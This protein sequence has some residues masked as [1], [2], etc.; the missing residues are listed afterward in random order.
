MVKKFCGVCVAALFILVAMW[1][2]DNDK[3]YRRY[4]GVAWN[5]S[6]HITY[7]SNVSLDD[8]IRT[9]M[10]TIEM[11][12]SPFNVNSLLSKV[13][14]NESD[15]IDELIRRVF[16]KSI[17]VNKIS[18]SKF[19]P[20]LGPLINLWGFG[21]ASITVLPDKG[22]VDSVMKY[23]G[24][25]DCRLIGEDRIAKKDSLTEF[26]F[27]AVAKGYGCDLVSQMLLRNGCKDYMVEVGGEIVV[28]GLSPRK[29]PWRVMIDAPIPS[30]DSIIHDGMAVIE[31]DS[32]SLATSGNYRN[33]RLIDGQMVGHTI[34]GETGYPANS[35]ILSVTV[36]APECIIADGL[37][38]ACMAMDLDDAFQMI[39]SLPDTEALFVTM[40]PDRQW[41]LHPTVGFPEI[42]R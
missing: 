22:D 5:T 7:A 10:N 28:N 21:T 15:S 33:Y 11:S 29:G 16:E 18:G 6:F 3:P 19:D 42:D 20:T 36:I 24:I 37:A 39:D 4:E 14:R 9:L 41:E 2:C 35:R 27:S 25:A 23:V 1:G 38:T 34:D 26:N 8:S 30:T 13:N 17:W 12:L 40:S 32:C 31:V